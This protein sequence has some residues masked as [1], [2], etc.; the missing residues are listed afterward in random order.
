MKDETICAD[1]D[2]MGNFSR[3]P[4][5]EATKNSKN[6]FWYIKNIFISLFRY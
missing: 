4:N 6:I 5:L 3:F 1:Y 2:S